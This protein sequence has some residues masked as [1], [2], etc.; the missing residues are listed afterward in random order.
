MKK[1]IYSIIIWI[2]CLGTIAADATFNAVTLA[3]QPNAET[4]LAGYR[5]YFSKST[6][7]W[8]H[9]KA[10]DL[11]TQATVELPSAGIWFFILTAKNQAGLESLPSNVATYTTPTGPGKPGNLRIASAVATQVSTVTTSTNLILVP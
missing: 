8:T 3:W 9:V 7:E 11:V 2:T 1:T 4:D 5:L 10:V 6:N